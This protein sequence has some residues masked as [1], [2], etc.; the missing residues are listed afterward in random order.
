MI[1][2]ERGNK[3]IEIE[4]GLP[5]IYRNVKNGDILHI[6]KIT[7]AVKN[8]NEYMALMHLSF[9]WHVEVKVNNGEFDT[10][11]S[12]GAVIRDMTSGIYEYGIDAFHG[13]DED[14]YMV[15]DKELIR[16][17]EKQYEY[18]RECC[19][20]GRDD[21]I[22]WTYVVPLNRTGKKVLSNVVPMCRVH[23]FARIRHAGWSA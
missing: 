22:V 5:S 6:D 18:N 23:H 3:T 12:S 8:I 15:Q 21:E 7:D 11:T 2:I 14:P 9:Y 20:C 4:N 10:T 17:A 19:G 16:E 1:K 13:W